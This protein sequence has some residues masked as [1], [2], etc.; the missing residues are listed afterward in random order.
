M[1]EKDFHRILKG[2]RTKESC[3]RQ[4]YTFYYPKIVFH[5]TM[6]FGESLAEDVAQEFFRDLLFSA[7]LP[8]RVK[9]PTLWVMRR[10]DAIAWNMIERD[11]RDHAYAEL[12]R[13]KYSPKDLRLLD[14]DFADLF[15]LLSVLDETTERI[16]VMHVCE[17]YGLNEV[18]ELLDMSYDAARKRFSR[19][20][21][22]M[23]DAASGAGMTDE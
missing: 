1:N 8:E 10:C 6:N 19:G 14:P 16:V 9:Y 21:K 12:G 22:R 4:L 11:N 18:A 7:E 23:R 17:G 3:F 5:I 20:I 13:K 15:V 2:L